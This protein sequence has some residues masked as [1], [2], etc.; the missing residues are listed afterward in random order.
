MHIL[1]TEAEELCF[2]KMPLES[3]LRQGRLAIIAGV[4]EE[5]QLDLNNEVEALLSALLARTNELLQT[6]LNPS[7]VPNEDILKGTPPLPR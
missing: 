5:L 7:R 1:D 2:I 4:L 3:E 6:T